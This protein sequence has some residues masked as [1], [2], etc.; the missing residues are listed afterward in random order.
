[1][2]LTPAPGKQYTSAPGGGLTL[3]G[4]SA[5]QGSDAIGVYNGTTLSWTGPAGTRFATQFYFYA[6]QN[7]IAFE[8][9]FLD[10]LTG[11]A[12]PSANAND[13][14]TASFPTF[15]VSETPAE[16]GLAYSAW[17][18]SMCAAH[19]ERWSQQT[20]FRFGHNAGVIALFNASATAVVMSAADAFMVSALAWPSG[21]GSKVF[22]AG[23]MVSALMGGRSRLSS[24]DHLPPQGTVNPIPAGFSHRTLLVAGQGVNETMHAWGEALL[25]LGGK[26]RPSA[27]VDI[28]VS[29][30]SYWTDNGK[31]SQCRPRTAKQHPPPP[32]PLIY[33]C[34]CRRLLLLPDAAQHDVR[35]DHARCEGVRD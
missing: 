27:D 3:S 11:S 35:A 22:G 18:G 33:T 1:M 15:L 25:R 34:T 8:Q 24:M 30:L 20:D 4:S 21:F 14:L 28:V 5:F 13:D 16:S 29:Q 23:L 31:Q 7:A 19:V 9:L 32:S 12:V 10:G 6:D 17:F 2:C 26:T